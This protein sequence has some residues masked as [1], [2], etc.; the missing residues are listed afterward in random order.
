MPKPLTLI[1]ILIVSIRKWHS[2]SLIFNN[3][4][5]RKKKI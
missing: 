2:F 1:K 3:E 5:V 4:K